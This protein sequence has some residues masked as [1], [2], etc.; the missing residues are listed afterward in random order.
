MY[1]DS[2]KLQMMYEAD[3]LRKRMYMLPRE[4]IFLDLDLPTQG[5]HQFANYNEEEQGDPQ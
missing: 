4:S 2:I 3:T 5:E 1:V